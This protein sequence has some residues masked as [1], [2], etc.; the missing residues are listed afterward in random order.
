MPI[1]VMRVCVCM[2]RLY[3][4][5]ALRTSHILCSILAISPRSRTVYSS[6]H[7]LLLS[8]LHYYNMRITVWNGSLGVRVFT[9]LLLCAV[10]KLTYSP[11]WIEID[12]LL[13][14]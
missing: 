9:M 1:D 5:H 7:N 6:T 2:C 10:D 3:N 12:M 8:F 11:M 13:H 4:V 14:L